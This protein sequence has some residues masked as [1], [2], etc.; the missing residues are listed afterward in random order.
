MF[1]CRVIPEIRDPEISLKISRQYYTKTFEI[2]VS[3]SGVAIKN[4]PLGAFEDILRAHLISQVPKF[5][6]FILT[7]I[8]RKDIIGTMVDTAFFK[9]ITTIKADTGEAIWAGKVGN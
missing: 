4:L 7:K 5:I 8:F 2:E 6:I 1:D 3:Q 9:T